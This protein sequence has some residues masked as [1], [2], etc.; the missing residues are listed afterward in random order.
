MIPSDAPDFY[1]KITPSVRERYRQFL[2]ARKRS[3]TSGLG[4]VLLGFLL[5]IPVFL[6]PIG[7]WLIIKGLRRNRG[8]PPEMDA[9]LK[10]SVPC[11]AEPGEQGRI[12]QMPYWVV[13]ENAPPPPWA[14]QCPV[15]L[16]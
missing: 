11:L 5:I 16:V 14:D 12:R 2:L 3:Q 7:I 15:M 4:L 10:F 6:A 1:E 13:F 8:R 9:E